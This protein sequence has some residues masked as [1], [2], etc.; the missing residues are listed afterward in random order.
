MIRAVLKWLLSWYDD[1]SVALLGR[2]QKLVEGF[3]V[4]REDAIKAQEGN[5]LAIGILINEQQKLAALIGRIAV[6][7]NPDQVQGS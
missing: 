1:T 4:L 3:M 5:A 2:E 7:A 6:D